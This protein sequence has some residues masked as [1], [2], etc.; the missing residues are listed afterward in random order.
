MLDGNGIRIKTIRESDLR[1]IY[2][3]EMDY[4]EAGDFMPVPLTSET[5]F[6][7]AYEKGGFW[8]DTCGKLLIENK[9]ET[10]VGDTP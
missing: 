10:V 9:D 8:R 7:S 2:E 4:S 3:L 1:A 5:D 6:R